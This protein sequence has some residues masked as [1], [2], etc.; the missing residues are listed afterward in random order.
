MSQC[1]TL[2]TQLYQLSSV[3]KQPDKPHGL[4]ARQAAVWARMPRNV[5]GYEA[6]ANVLIDNQ[7]ISFALDDSWG[8]G[9]FKSDSRCVAHTYDPSLG[10]MYGM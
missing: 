5:A 9:R 6:L 10:Y 1:Q 8:S 2:P 4:A 7:Y 3:C